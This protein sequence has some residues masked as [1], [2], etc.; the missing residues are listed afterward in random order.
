M[1]ESIET[2]D[3]VGE[4]SRGVVSVTVGATIVTGISSSVVI[5]STGAG[6]STGI[7]TSAVSTGT[8]SN[9]LNMLAVGQS[10]FLMTKLQITDFPENYISYANKFS[11]TM[12]DAPVP[13]EDEA[14]SQD[15]NDLITIRYERS[16]FETFSRIYFYQIVIFFLVIFLHISASALVLFFRMTYPAI[17]RFPRLEIMYLFFAMPSIAAGSAALLKSNE[18]WERNLG[19]ALLIVFPFTFILWNVMVI[20][21]AFFKVEPEDWKACFEVS[22]DNK[23]DSS[24]KSGKENKEYRNIDLFEYILTP[25][26]GSPYVKAEWKSSRGPENRFIL[27]YGPIFE[28][29]RGFLVHRR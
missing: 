25:L 14:P 15:N 7:T 19:I 16:P 13:W 10:I 2:A 5:S 20:Y 3:D 27:R 9:A 11:W 29:N 18:N 8:L 4:A 17:L 23:S 22:E 1:E 28:E 6:V 26:L 21:R 24:S 12:Y